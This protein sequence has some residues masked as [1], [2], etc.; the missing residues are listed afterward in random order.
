MLSNKQNLLDYLTYN[1]TPKDIERKQFGGF[2]TPIPVVEE[3]LNLLQVELWSDPIMTW[4]DPCVEI[5]NLMVSFITSYLK[6]FEKNTR[7]STFS[8]YYH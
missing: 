6:N 8:I 4:F 2:F 7:C 1:L 5:D 3:M